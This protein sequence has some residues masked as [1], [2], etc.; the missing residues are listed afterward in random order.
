MQQVISERERRMALL[1]P[2]ARV[3]V[4]T[5]FYG[6]DLHDHRGTLVAIDQRS[7]YPYAVQVQEVPGYPDGAI[8]SFA[9]Y[10][11]DLLGGGGR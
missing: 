1:V 3:R 4:T 10:E 8:R 2:N 6:P 7:L 9:W 11:I 5:T